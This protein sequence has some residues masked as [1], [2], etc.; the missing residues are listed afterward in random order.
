MAKFYIISPANFET[1]GVE[2]LHQLVY[3]L[4]KIKDNCA[5]IYYYNYDFSKLKHPTPDAYLKYTEG[6]FVTKIIDNE[7]HLLII[8]E[9]Y[10]NYIANYKNIKI[11]VWWL[12]VDNF[13]SSI[14]SINKGKKYSYK[15]YGKG[16]KFILFKWLNYLNIKPS[17]PYD[18]FINNVLFNKRLLLHAYQSEYAR[19]F[20]VEKKLKPILALSDFLNS[21]FFHSQITKVDRSDVILYNPK[22]GFE[23]IEHL[24]AFMPKYKWI[25]LENLTTI[26][27]KKLIGK[28]KIYVDFGNHPGKDRIPREAAINGCVVITN[29]KGSANNSIDLS[30]NDEYKFEDPI[31]EKKAFKN[32]V[33]DI[34]LDFEKHFHQFD[35]Y[36]SKINNEENIFEKELLIFY[37]KCSR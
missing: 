27:M 13:Y 37:D 6:D 2:L 35:S 32:M 11:V 19:N 15:E 1:G 7:H 12:S 23:I 24:M 31:K 25:A 8:P 14:E 20:L 26:E 34:Y 28:S 22:K 10:T 29:R 33:D 9:I 30:I 4:N 3:K 17:Y 5:V 18:P 36:R 21:N 16:K